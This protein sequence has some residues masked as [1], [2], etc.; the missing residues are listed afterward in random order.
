MRAVGLF[1]LQP[2]LAGLLAEV[3]S[4]L[5]RNRIDD[6]VAITWARDPSRG[7]T[8]DIELD[9]SDMTRV[10]VDW[11]VPVSLAAEPSEGGA[12]VLVLRTEARCARISARLSLGAAHAVLTAGGVALKPGAPLPAAGG[13]PRVR[14][15]FHR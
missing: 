3:S 9:V 14:T 2:T 4:F 7:W 15:E 1:D 12:G 6:P 5:A 11:P 13:A 10:F 8:A